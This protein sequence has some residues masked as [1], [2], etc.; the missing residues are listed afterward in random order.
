MAPRIKPA[1]DAPT[2]CE[3]R[4]IRNTHACTLSLDGPET[5]IIASQARR[6]TRMSESCETLYGVHQNLYW[7]DHAG[8]A[9]QSVQWVGERVGT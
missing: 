9:V 2:G 3:G 4:E 8:T 7:L 1:R 5:I 6:L